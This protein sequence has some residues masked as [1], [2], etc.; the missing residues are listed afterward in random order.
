MTVSYTH[1]DVYKRQQSLSIRLVTFTCFK[2]SSGQNHEDEELPWKMSGFSKMALRHTPWTIQWIFFDACFVDASFHVL[3][4]FRGLQDL[5]TCQC[6]TFSCESTS[7]GVCTLT[8][9]AI[10]MSWRMPSLKRRWPVWSRIYSGDCSQEDGRHVA[11]I[12][13]HN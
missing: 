4:M 9:H 7:K 13:F 8:N 2:C 12:I 1:L 6:E 3:A 5:P 10:W 11:D